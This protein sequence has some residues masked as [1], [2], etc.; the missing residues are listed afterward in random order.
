VN[1]VAALLLIAFGATVLAALGRFALAATGNGSWLEFGLDV[2]SALTL[3]FGSFAASPALDT[4]AES[5]TQ[6]AGESGVEKYFGTFAGKLIG[7]TRAADFAAQWAKADAEAAAMAAQKAPVLQRAWNVFKAGGNLKDM[8]T[9]A[10]ISGLT[11]QYG[12]QGVKMATAVANGNTALNTLRLTSGVASG[13]GTIGL[14]GSGGQLLNL[15]GQEIFRLHI[16]GV[17]DLWDQAVH[18]TTHAIPGWR[19]AVSNAGG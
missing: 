15:Q 6:A 9:A 4:A 3:G 1:I 8:M 5:A 10:K 19:I 16:P 13:L 7:Q 11:A 12:T 2:V 17:S 14:V 18:N